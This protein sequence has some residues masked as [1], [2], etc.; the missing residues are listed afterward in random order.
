MKER[1]PFSYTLG[2]GPYLFVDFF[3]LVL[4]SEA[5]Q[6]RNNFHM[7]PKNLKSGVGTCAHCG[8]GIINNYIVKN[9]V[10]ER[11]AIGSECI[12]KA[13]S[14]SQVVNMSTFEKHQ[15]KLRSEQSKARREAQ[16]IKLASEVY[17]VIMAN[18][19]TLKGLPHPSKY[20]PTKT[21]FD[22]CSFIFKR[23]YVSIGSSKLLK[24][25]LTEWN[26]K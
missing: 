23:A 15:A 7:A 11:F 9:G 8:H 4:P 17:G 6:G 21:A 1:H 25:K 12:L 22:Y 2:L 5:N 3:A 18:Q 14:E 26:C 24:K 19:H 13:N 16:R 10:G 20:H